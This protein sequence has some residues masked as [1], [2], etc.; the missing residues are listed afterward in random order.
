MAGRRTPCA[1]FT[2]ELLAAGAMDWLKFYQFW[3]DGEPFEY[4]FPAGPATLTSRQAEDTAHREGLRLTAQTKFLI[5]V[6]LE[7]KH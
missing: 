2:R 1:A 7:T 6:D 3:Y 5:D 4:V